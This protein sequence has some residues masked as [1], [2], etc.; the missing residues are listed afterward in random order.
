MKSTKKE[1]SEPN[2][3]VESKSL[4]RGVDARRAVEKP[5]E[6]M[7]VSTQALADTSRKGKAGE[8]SKL[9]VSETFDPATD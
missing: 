4:K 3:D 2:A 7:G 1:T 6:V 5:H 8:K 9:E